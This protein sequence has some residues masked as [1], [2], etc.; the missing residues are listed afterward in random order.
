MKPPGL[1]T[2]APISR[3]TNNRRSSLSCADT[4]L[5]SVSDRA[6]VFILGTVLILTAL[7]ERSR[8]PEAF[9]WS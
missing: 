2:A 7:F 3:I 8:N 6:G 4:P 1:K 9:R 5:I